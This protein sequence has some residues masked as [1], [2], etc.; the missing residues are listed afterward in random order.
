MHG[1]QMT[2]P[3]LAECT[4]MP[5]MRGL[6]PTSMHSVFMA[7]G[8]QQEQQQQQQRADGIAHLRAHV[9]FLLCSYLGC[10]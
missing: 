10:Y 9:V 6:R 8:Q 3:G 2:Q 5:K 7:K 4:T 1:E